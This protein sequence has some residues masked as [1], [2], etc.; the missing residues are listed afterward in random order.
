MSELEKV[1]FE[2]EYGI[3]AQSDFPDW[4]DEMEL[5]SECYND[6]CAALYAMSRADLRNIPACDFQGATGSYAAMN[7][8]SAY[9][10]HVP[11]YH[12]VA[13]RMREEMPSNR[14]GCSK[15]SVVLKVASGQTF[16]CERV[17]SPVMLMDE[18]EKMSKERGSYPFATRPAHGFFGF[19]AE[20]GL[21]FAARNEG[22]GKPV[23]AFQ[24]QL[25]RLAQSTALASGGFYDADAFRDR[26][27]E[28]GISISSTYPDMLAKEFHNERALGNMKVT[29]EKLVPTS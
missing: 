24:G 10:E 1:V 28:L 18:I 16:S 3:L 6:P 7:R 25:K 2:V 20:E 17:C 22:E 9:G 8:I 23:R 29:H 13:L 19:A 26:C 21:I 5:R 12:R 4:P 15:A 11:D 14:F 27:R